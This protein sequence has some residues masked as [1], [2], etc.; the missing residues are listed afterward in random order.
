MI[1]PSPR[2]V[3]RST[4]SRS[5]AVTEPTPDEPSVV[6]RARA[7]SET[8]AQ[9]IFDRFVEKLMLH[10]R[11]RIGTRMNSR[12]DPEDVVQSVFRTFFTRLKNDQFQIADQD[13]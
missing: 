3:N 2:P 11:R 6:A 5:L 13:D 1:G 4:L 7:G 10:A 12:V 8:A 9:E